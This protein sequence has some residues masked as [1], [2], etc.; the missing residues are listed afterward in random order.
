MNFSQML[1]GYFAI[2]VYGV[3]V[4]IAFIVGA[5]LYYKALKKENYSLDTFLHFFWRWIL[6]GFASGRLF[7]F[8]IH[9]SGLLER[10]GQLAF[11]AFWDEGFHF[12]GFLIGFL[13]LMIFDLR[14]RKIDALRW[15]DTLVKPFLVAVL[16]M[17]IAGFLTGHVYGK[18]TS[19]WW[20]IQYETFTV[21]ILNPIHPVTIYAFLFHAWL[22]FWISRSHT[23]LTTY[24]GKLAIRFAILFFGFELFLEFFKG[25]PTLIIFDFLRV[26]QIL[27]LVALIFLFIFGHL[28]KKSIATQNQSQTEKQ[29][30]QDI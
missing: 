17:D 30:L 9:L 5:S 15:I 12:L 4:A 8:L 23:I 16:I 22:L 20:G 14:T 28:H 29:E 6:V 27:L 25:N 1:F 3:F 10:N 2:K 11:F 13:T 24:S 21:D 7:S 26:N 19:L 18:E